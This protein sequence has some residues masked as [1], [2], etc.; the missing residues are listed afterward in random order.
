MTLRINWFGLAAGIVTLLALAASLNTPWWRITIGQNLIGVDAN[1]FNTSFSLLGTQITIPLIW[2]INLIFILA[3]AT[4]GI[5]LLIYSLMPTK[6]YG[7]DLLG[8]SYRK[9]VYVVIIFVVFLL[10]IVG[11]PSLIGLHIPL[12]GSAVVTP[13]IS[14]FLGGLAGNQFSGLLPGGSLASTGGLFS[15]VTVGVLVSSSLQLG[16]WLAILA[17]A[18]CIAA[19]L[20]H[21]HVAKPLIKPV[22]AMTPPT[23]QQPEASVPQTLQQ[24]EEMP[25]TS[26]QQPEEQAKDV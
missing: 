23:S 11:I 21:S 6:P 16:F 8:F 12:N 7:M 26:Q 17:A 19:R 18:L 2:M 15:G 3:F 13:S 20:Y 9:P 14:S 5:V 4:S 10:I 1:P 25:P 24:P 22:T